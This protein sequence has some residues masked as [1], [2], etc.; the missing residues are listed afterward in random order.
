[1][2]I[3]NRKANKIQLKDSGWNSVGGSGF[4]CIKIV[5]SMRNHFVSD[6]LRAKSLFSTRWKIGKLLGTIIKGG[7]A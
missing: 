7:I 1:M 6:I 2:K 4:G 5:D 3:S